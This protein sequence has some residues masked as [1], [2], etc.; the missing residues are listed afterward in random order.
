M[1]FFLK[2]EIPHFNYD[3]EKV[4]IKNSLGKGDENFEENDKINCN[5]NFMKISESF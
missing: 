4:T 1:V 3:Q 2:I 5:L